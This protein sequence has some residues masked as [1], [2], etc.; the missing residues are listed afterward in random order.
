MVTFARNGKLRAS[1]ASVNQDE[2]R[3]IA[4][5]GPCGMCPKEHSFALNLR[6]Q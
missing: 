6:G 3:S 4:A 2:S 1:A 5:N